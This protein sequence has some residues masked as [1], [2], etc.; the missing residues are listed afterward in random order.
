METLL[1][2][3]MQNNIIRPF[4]MRRLRALV[5]KRN[6]ELNRLVRIVINFNEQTATTSFLLKVRNIVIASLPDASDD[7]AVKNLVQQAHI[8]RI[9]NRHNINYSKL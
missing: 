7:N 2:N 1:N 8:L 6:E 9:K 5:I 3:W 4:R